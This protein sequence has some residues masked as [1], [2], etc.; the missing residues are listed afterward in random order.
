[1]N[2]YTY[3]YLREDGTPYYI[4]KGK[5]NRIHS[6]SNRVFNPPPKVKSG[7]IR[8]IHKDIKKLDCNEALFK[9]VVKTTF[10][11]RRKT[12]RNTIK[13]LLKGATF[14][15]P[16]L[17]E[18]PEQLSVEQFVQLTKEVERLIGE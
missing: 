11:Q 18:R 5:G 2:Y 9:A 13:P 8:L 15:H 17:T 4:G 14:E 7:V 12:I 6:K 10:N 16:L 1:M 3:A